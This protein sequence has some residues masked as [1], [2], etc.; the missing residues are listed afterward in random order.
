MN[1]QESLDLFFK[2]GSMFQKQPSTRPS[3]SSLHPGTPPVVRVWTEWN[4]RASQFA[5]KVEGQGSTLFQSELWLSLWYEIFTTT[6]EIEAVIIALEDAHTG[7]LLMLLPLCKR[8]ENGLSIISFADFGLADYN[9]PLMHPDYKPKGRQIRELLQIICKALPHA[10]LLKLEK[11]PEQVVELKNPLNYL[12]GV[13]ESN[14]CHFG[15]EVAGSW[16]E[17]WTTLKRN[18]RKDQRRRWRVLEKKG[19]V[20][21]IWCRDKTE[22]LE[23]FEVLLIQQQKRLQKL[24]LSYLLEDPRMKK[25]YEQIIKKGCTDGPVIFTAL[26][27]DGQPIATLCGFGDGRRYAM[28]ASGYEMGEWQKCSPGRLLT[29]RTMQV[30]HENG[31]SYFDF[32]I[33]DEPYKKYFAI[34]HGPLNEY[35]RPLAWRALPRYSWMKVKA[36]QRKSDFAQSIKR[37]ISKSHSPLS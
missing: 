22:A 11:L 18:F 35:Y 1:P 27:V 12:K 36:A 2:T 3:T 34:E 4:E 37:M 6:P 32:T 10:D 7:E 31:Y 17:Y 25:F 30:L 29:E 8:M 13:Q 28:T 20:S 16:D 5:K 14:L 26:L 33:G 19:K 9:A 21:F 24:N 23:L 15:I